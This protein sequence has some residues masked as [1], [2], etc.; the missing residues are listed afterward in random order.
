MKVILKSDVSKLGKAGTL[1]DVSDGHAR[2]F[3]I[4]KGLAVEATPA[5]L[6]EWKNEQ[7]RLKAKDDKNRAEAL[8]LQKALQ[9]KAVVVEGKAGENGKL[10][11]SIT[12]AQ[13]SEALEH[14]HGLKNF[15]KRN[16]K[17]DDAVKQPGNFP[18]SLKLYPGIQADMTLTVKVS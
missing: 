4:P 10:F 7:A 9:G 3:L 16:I 6:S 8:E 14:Q 11:G 12:A 18:I 2:N 1:I 17:L 5:K 15:D 13:V